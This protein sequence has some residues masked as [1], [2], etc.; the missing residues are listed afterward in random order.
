MTARLTDNETLNRFELDESGQTVF[1]DY[2]IADGR[3][4]IDHVESPIA[5]RGSG[6]AGRLM[7]LIA[8][9]ARETNLQIVPICGYAAAWLRRNA[10]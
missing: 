2:R 3:L 6:A 7:A 1:A 8:E 9:H 4:F 10:A 5:L